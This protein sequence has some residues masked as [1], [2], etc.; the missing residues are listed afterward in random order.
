VL[1]RLR[2]LAESLANHQWM[3]LLFAG[4]VIL[5]PVAF[6]ALLAGKAW[7]FI[8]ALAASAFLDGLLRMA[9][10][11]RGRLLQVLR[12]RAAQSSTLRIALVAVAF[13]VLADARTA[14][15]LTG[16]G[17]V[18]SLL[19][20]IGVGWLQEY[21]ARAGWDFAPGHSTAPGGDQWFEQAGAAQRYTRGLAITE[22]LCIAALAIAV[23]GV[24]DT[25]VVALVVI[26]WIPSLELVLVPAWR[27]LRIPGRA[28]IQLTA[29]VVPG[30][31]AVYFADPV[32]RAYQLEQW[33]P[34]LADLHRDLGVLL[35]LRD[36]RVFNLFGDLSDLP[37]FYARTL[38]ELAEMYAVGN[39]GVVLYV[40]NGWRN[41]QSLA[42][43]LALHAH[44][45]HG[46]SDKTS[47]VTHQSRAYDRVLVAGSAAIDRMADGLLEVDT[48][49]AV[50]VGRPQLDYVDVAAEVESSPRAAVVYA[51]TW[52]GENDANNFSSVDI[53]GPAIVQALLTVPDVTVLYK[54]HPRTPASPQR[55]M[56]DA[57]R[58]ICRQLAAAAA[59]DPSGGH[60]L[61]AGDILSLLARADVL[62]SD[63]SSVAIDHLYLRPDA[64][65]VLMDRGR[66]GGDVKAAEIPIAR[67]ATVLRA[68]RPGD[69]PAAVI[70]LLASPGEGPLR[71]EVRHQYFGDY[72]VGESTRRF[73][74]VVA[75]LVAL[76]DERVAASGAARSVSIDSAS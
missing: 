9:P 66:D 42:W 59:A 75:E 60:G 53:G 10:V 22:V 12:E 19:A 41:F 16:A 7:A 20:R 50:I 63:V 72:E 4:S 23:G 44:I 28:G 35:V 58:A 33:L 32:S 46:E 56:R 37:R 30:R 52:E 1:D 73:Q 31:V 76:R 8:A 68:D 39:H 55:A 14:A 24:A 61:W 70:A 27:W 5:L 6:V 54:P 18:F 62:I 69:L 51:P 43:P 2:E 26:G 36:R 29:D 48:T 74:T 47:L 71:A 49:T 34:V 13:D 25:V 65:L 15:V 21:A 38:D 3:R 64:G 67:G 11:S 40:N 17:L 57:H 45:N